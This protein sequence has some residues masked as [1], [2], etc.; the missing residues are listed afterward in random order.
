MLG[1][2]GTTQDADIAQRE[3]LYLVLPHTIH[4][5]LKLWFFGKIIPDVFAACPYYANFI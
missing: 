1:E 2:R 4:P 3:T 5:A